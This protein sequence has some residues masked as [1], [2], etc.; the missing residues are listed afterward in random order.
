MALQLLNS[1]GRV[2][3]PLWGV[4]RPTPPAH[5]AV[6]VAILLMALVSTTAPVVLRTAVPSSRDPEK[7]SAHV[8]GN[9]VSGFEDEDRS[10]LRTSSRSSGYSSGGLPI[11][12]FL[13]FLLLLLNTVLLINENINN[14][15]N[16]NNNNNNNN[17]DQR[18]RRNTYLGEAMSHYLQ[19]VEAY[20]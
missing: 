2:A 5:M 16:D 12:G 17:N 14:N 11:F 4:S 6:L 7:H 10:I 19:S 1:S 13:S 9:D 18:R 15:N 20:S 8:N 3:T